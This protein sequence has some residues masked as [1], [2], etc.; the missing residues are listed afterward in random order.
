M[1][2]KETILLGY[3]GHAYVVIHCLTPEHNVVG[4]LEPEE[5]SQNPFELKYFGKETEINADDFKSQYFFPAIGSNELRKKFVAF[6]KEKNLRET[7]AIDD[8]AI[9]AS[10]AS[11]GKSTMIGPGAIVN[12]LAKIGIG[13]IINSGAI[14][15]HE[16]SIGDFVHVAPG[17]VLAGNVTVGEGAFIGANSTIKEGVTIGE[18]AVIGAGSV[19]LRDVP[20]NQTWAGVPAKNINHGK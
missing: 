13:V 6:I 8:T 18:N 3:S 2:N 7:R 17:T 20:A 12:P 5:K 10:L 16:C 11:I 19:V 14:I 9:V 15:E 4:Y 1:S